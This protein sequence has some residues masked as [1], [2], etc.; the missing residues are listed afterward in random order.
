MRQKPQTGHLKSTIMIRRHAA[1]GPVFCPSLH[2][3][4][5]SHSDV[6]RI[7]ATSISRSCGTSVGMDETQSV[8]S[9]AEQKKT[10]RK[11]KTD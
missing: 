3:D 5:A 2:I 1:N 6:L 4:S 8:E 7:R 9:A 10:G 11:L